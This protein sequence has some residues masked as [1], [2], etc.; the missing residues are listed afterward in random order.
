MRAGKALYEQ[1]WHADARTGLEIEASL[2]AGLI[3]STNQIEAVK[4]NFN[5][6]RVCTG[7]SSPRTLV[8]YELGKRSKSCSGDGLAQQQGGE[9]GIAKQHARGRMTIRE[10]IDVLLDEGPSVS[11][12]EQP[13]VRYT[14]IMTSWWNMPW[15]TTSWFWCYWRS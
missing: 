10:R 2:Q 4:A 3:G 1:A 11:T 12:V 9:A 14:M 13:P 6:R 7:V 15:R 5:A 8:I